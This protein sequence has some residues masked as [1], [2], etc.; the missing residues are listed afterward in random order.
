MK[1]VAGLWEEYRVELLKTLDDLP[2]ELA[3]AAVELAKQA[4]LDGIVSILGELTQQVEEFA[5]ELV[6]EEEEHDG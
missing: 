4:F 2:P 3:Q 1:T 6:P 5:P